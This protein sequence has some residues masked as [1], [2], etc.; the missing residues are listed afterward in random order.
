M[1]Q[2]DVFRNSNPHSQAHFP[3]L[4]EV[5]SNLLVDL[6]STMVVPLCLESVQRHLSITH[7]TPVF[8]IKADTYLM[9]T[10]QLT[11]MYRKELGEFVLN[12]G[13]QQ[14]TIADALDILLKGI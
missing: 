3:Y 9:M 7:L 14:N 6:A 1:A 12:M 2:F 8:K 11:G 4:L 5:Q 13:R 10:P